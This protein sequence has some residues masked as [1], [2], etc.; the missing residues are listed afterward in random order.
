MENKSNTPDFGPPPQHG[1][2]WPCMW[3]GMKL[4]CPSC[5]GG[6]LFRSY[7]KPVDHCSNCNQ[8]WEHVRADLAPAWAAMTLAAHLTVLIWHFFFW[9]TEIPSW[10]LTLILSAIGTLICLISLPM[11][12]GLFMAIV[13]SKGT[14]DS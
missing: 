11:M 5:G 10:Q 1:S 13:W 8:R 3:R 9:R 14:R 12:K 6:K 2:V 7:L 4:R